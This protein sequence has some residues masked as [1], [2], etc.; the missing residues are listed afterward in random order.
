M[1]VHY[2]TLGLI[3]KKTDRGEADQ[4]LTIFTK[5]FGKLEILGKAIRKIS[6][7]LRSGAELFCFSE[8]EF[9]QGKAYKTLTDAIL[10]EKFKNIK[11]DLEKI[12]AAYQITDALDNLVRGQE[13]DEAIFN[14]LNESFNKLNDCQLSITAC[15]LL[16]YYFLWNLFS[17]LGYEIDL[18]CCVI[19][20]KR[21]S[22]SNLY[23]SVEEGGIVCGECLDKAAKCGVISADI[24][25]IIRL[26][27]KKDWK[28]LLK[29]KIEK[30]HLDSLKLISE[31]YLS[32]YQKTE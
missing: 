12:K 27:L 26:F 30:E 32:Y 14:L 7:K 3:L 15:Q 22:P 2:R 31:S 19:C 9:I 10:I 17:S 11:N 24:I 28:T 18:Y 25:K 13:K 16:C 29:I 6:S 23:F 1:A 20:Q 21:L 4:V 8:I 5:D